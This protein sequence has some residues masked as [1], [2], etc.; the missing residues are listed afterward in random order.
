MFTVEALKLTAHG[1]SFDL[2]VEVEPSTCLL[3]VTRFRLSCWG[4]PSAMEALKL[5]T[6]TDTPGVQMFMSYDGGAVPASL[7]TIQ[8]SMVG[9]PGV[10]GSSTRSTES[11]GKGSEATVG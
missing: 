6:Q 8:A 10:P 3:H 1:H 9:S 2:C 11:E 4:P 7:D 5:T